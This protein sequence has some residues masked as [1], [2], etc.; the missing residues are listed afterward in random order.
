MATKIS[1]VLEVPLDY[2]VAKIKLEL[3]LAAINRLQ[4]VTRLSNKDKEHIFI[5][6][7]AMIRDFKNK[8]AFGIAQR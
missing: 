8:Q 4:E 7:D 3:D 5:T 2:L 1:E 6:L